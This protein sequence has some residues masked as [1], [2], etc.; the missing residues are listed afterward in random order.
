[1]LS[2]WFHKA[3]VESGGGWFAPSYRKEAEDCGIEMATKVGLP[4]ADA[5][6][7]QLR[8][9]SIDKLKSM[10]K[11]C[12]ASV[13]GRL[14]VEGPTIAFLAGRAADIPL[15]IGVNSG[16]DSLLDHGDGIARAK[17]SMQ[18]T[19]PDARKVYGDQMSDED[20]VRVL[21]RDFLAMAPARWIAGES[22]RAQ[23]A[24]LYYFDYVDEAR[25]AGPAEL[26]RTA[27]KVLY[28]FGTI[29]ASTGRR[30]AGDTGR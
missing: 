8:S 27:P 29:R 22:W 23:P 4:G 17:A 21:F 14:A 20:L 12:A 13:D 5:T 10:D 9:L 11:I 15:L 24:F 28:V 26:A 16:E 7:Q 19:L 3:I 25:S 1:V 30:S 6:L 18:S 2:P